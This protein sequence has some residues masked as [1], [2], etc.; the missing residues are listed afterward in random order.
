MLTDVVMPGMSG[1]ELA[2]RIAGSRPET[3]VLYM[4]GYSAEALGNRG[5]LEPGIAL[6][7]KPFTPKS[8]VQAVRD[9]LSRHLSAHRS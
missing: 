4:S 2:E 8:L 9:A 1:R 5:V 6:L 3:A 7:V